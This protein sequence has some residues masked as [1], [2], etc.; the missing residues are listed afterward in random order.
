MTSQMVIFRAF[1]WFF[2]EF[3]YIFFLEYLQKNGKTS[4]IIFKY[5]IIFLKI[6]TGQSLLTVPLSKMH[7]Q[8]L[9]KI[10]FFS[11]KQ[12]ILRVSSRI[13]IKILEIIFYFFPTFRKIQ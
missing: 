8:N 10:S 9:K 5:F 6:W 3:F 1:V 2:S 13:V 7:R 11:T 4:N 12:L